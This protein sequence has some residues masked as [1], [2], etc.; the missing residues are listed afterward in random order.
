MTIEEI[1]EQKDTISK[2]VLLKEVEKRQEWLFYAKM[3]D[4]YDV[5]EIQRVRNILAEIGEIIDGKS[6]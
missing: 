3:A 1:R 5:F 4:N 2:E 6:E